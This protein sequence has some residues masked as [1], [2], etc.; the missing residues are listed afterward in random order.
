LAS[1]AGRSLWRS[2]GAVACAAVWLGACARP[3]VVV[4]AI[5]RETAGGVARGYVASVDLTD[6]RVRVVVSAPTIRD[7]GAAEME[8]TP[9]FAEREEATVAINANYFGE[10][11]GTGTAR[12]VGLVVRDAR[13][14][15]PARV[16]G[17]LPDPALVVDDRSGRVELA[18]GAAGAE[19][20]VAGVG[21]SGTDATPGTLLVDDGKN[22]G[23]TAR[24]DPGVR[25]PRT[26]AGVSKDGRTLYLVVVDGRQEGWSVGMTLPELG[27][28]IAE[29][30]AY[31]AV[32]LDGGGSSSFVYRPAGG[33]AKANRPSDG[34]FR[35]VAV[36]LG[37]VVEGG[38]N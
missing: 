16:Y 27:D 10:I 14:V 29:F 30:G 15:S 17:A 31:D 13:E 22:L 11:K 5:E 2:V 25:H 9:A 7:G 28:L 6:P 23:G 12:I 33:E 18:S 24:V 4:D 3:A 37:V 20:A 1:V 26:A 38:M 19:A 35:P 34:A 32:N 36:S 21:P 8:P